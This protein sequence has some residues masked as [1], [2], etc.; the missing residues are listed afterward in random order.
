MT[1]FGQRQAAFLSPLPRL[2]LAV[3][4][5]VLGA[6]LAGAVILHGHRVL[7]VYGG[8]YPGGNCLIPVTRLVRPDWVDPLALGICL[9]GLAGAAGILLATRRRST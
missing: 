7:H 5:L 9:L 6:A 1:E 8:C 4:A 2:R 3:A